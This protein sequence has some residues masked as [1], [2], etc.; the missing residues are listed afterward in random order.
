M[1]NQ[2]PEPD[3]SLTLMLR[4]QK[5]PADGAAWSEFVQQYRPM[6]LRLVLEV[7]IAELRR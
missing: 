7:G 6:I 2:K 4:L 3:T 1:S 5:N